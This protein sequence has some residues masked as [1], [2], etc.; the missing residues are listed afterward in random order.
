MS[1][2]GIECHFFFGSLVVSAL[3]RFAGGEDQTFFDSDVHF[4]ELPNEPFAQAMAGFVFEQ[5]DVVLGGRDS[6]ATVAGGFVFVVDRQH[7]HG[8]GLWIRR[9]K[10]AEVQ[11]RAE[12]DV[13]QIRR[14]AVIT[15]DGI[16]QQSERIRG[17]PEVGAFSRNAHTAAA[18]GMIHED[19]F[20]TVGVCFF[21]RGELSRFRAEN[22]SS[23]FFVPGAWFL[24]GSSRLNERR[25][26]KHRDPRTRNEEQGTVS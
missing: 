13:P 12:R 2:G 8:G 19:E 20:A 16:R 22:L 3:L 1:G 18:V 4:L 14:C 10:G 15:H 26:H 21:Q 7:R 11:H 9:K 23:W 6:F 5:K 25:A 17:I 24:V